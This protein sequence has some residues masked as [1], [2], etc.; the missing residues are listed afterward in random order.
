MCFSNS[1]GTATPLPTIFEGDLSARVSRVE[2][3]LRG[4]LRLKTAL[5]LKNRIGKTGVRVKNAAPLFGSNVHPGEI[6][7]GRAMSAEP[8][9]TCCGVAGEEALAFRLGSQFPGPRSRKERPPRPQVATVAR[10]S[11]VG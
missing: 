9:R 10:S 11:V 1:R 7:Y 8:L 2:A 5:A 4:R 6:W 3:P